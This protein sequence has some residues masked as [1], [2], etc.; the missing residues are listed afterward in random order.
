MLLADAA[1]AQLGT[2]DLGSTSVTT[3]PAVRLN[4]RR[5]DPT[6]PPGKGRARMY[7]IPGD[8]PGAFT[9]RIQIGDNP[10]PYSIFINGSEAP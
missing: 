5:Q 4:I 9:L 10:T 8:V 2:S 3:P 1:Q 7:L 6:L